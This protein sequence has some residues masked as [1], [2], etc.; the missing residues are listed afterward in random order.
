[1]DPRWVNLQLLM[2]HEGHEQH[3]CFLSNLGLFDRVKEYA[4]RADHAEQFI[5]RRC[6]RSSYS[7][8]HLCEPE[9]L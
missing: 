4:K 7:A 6:G 2:P 9:K 5:C 8:A 1:M 3:L